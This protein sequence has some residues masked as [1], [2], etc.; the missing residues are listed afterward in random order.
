MTT[1][2]AVIGAG[3]GGYV[4]A[5]RASQLGARVTLIE[6]EAVGGACLHCGCIPSKIIK[7]TAEMFHKMSQASD[8]G[9][10][11]TG[12]LSVNMKQLMARKA[13]IIGTQVRGIES[14]LKH[15]S[16]ELI[17]G[18]A[19]L[20]APGRLKV[21]A[22]DG[23][24][25]EVNWDRLIISAGTVPM[26]LP[27]A[28]FDG[29]QIISSNEALNLNELPESIVIVGAGVIGCEFA[30]MLSAM[31]CR[32]SLVEALDRVLPLPSVD[33]ACSKVLAREMKKRK[34]RALLKHT[35][36]EVNSN[37][38]ELNI[39]AGP[40]QGDG[41]PLE[42]SAEKMLVCIGRSSN[43]PALG[44]DNI[45]LE[46]DARGWISVDEQLR[47]KVDGVF[48]IGDILGPQNIMLAHVASAEGITAAANAMG[49]KRRMHYHAVPSAIFTM[50]EVATVGLTQQQAKDRGIDVKA[51]SVLFRVMGKAQAM[52]EI[53]GEV[54]LVFDGSNQK[55][56]GM[57]MIGPHVTDLIAEATLAV[58]A[59]H[60]VDQVADTIHAHPTLAE[61]VGEAAMKAAGRA[62]HG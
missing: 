21:T 7:N 40:V 3:P 19:A 31:G 30:C 48:A 56:L 58:N 22:G 24:V 16:V 54:K 59:G 39:I 60:S 5:V 1:H 45:G 57:H 53:T 2:I 18:Q 52:G 33:A 61:A 6:K 37:G 13:R 41:K 14:L 38:S 9:I 43:A 12:E 26:A 51:A 42:L 35:V 17:H 44:L 25:S 4:A 36:K 10:D 50:P 32:V 23:G 20:T 46:T 11:L 55:I 15:H 28:P 34:I 29:R 62:L 8:L 49:E 27:A 47:T